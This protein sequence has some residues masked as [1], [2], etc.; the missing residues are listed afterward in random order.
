MLWISKV[1]M[2]AGVVLAV[3][4]AG[5]GTGLAVRNSWAGAGQDARPE[6]R[7]QAAGLPGAPSQ[8]ER[9]AKGQGGK[10]LMGDPAQLSPGARLDLEVRKL[11]DQLAAALKE[12]EDL[13]ANKAFKEGAA[14][15]QVRIEVIPLKN[16]AAVQVARV[17]GDLFQGYGIT[18]AALPDNNS[19]LVR[20][21]AAE[22][23]R[24]RDL[25]VQSLDSRGDQDLDV[26]ISAYT[27]GPLKHARAADVA[28]VLRSVYGRSTAGAPLEGNVDARNPVKGGAF[29]VAVDERTNSLVLA[30]TVARYEEA[31]VLTQRLEEAAAHAPAAGARLIGLKNAAAVDVAKVLRDIYGTADKSTAFSA[32]PRSNRLVIRCPESLA[33]EIDILVCE[34]D[35]K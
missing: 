27:L 17:L 32:D 3:L 29:S 30:C 33:A 7:A 9:N 1:K 21:N 18:V 11:R 16:A 24:I 14:P 26:S 5:T 15:G 2:A 23:R 25:V 31:R 34:L 19:L 6:A 13:K 20:A 10:G 22:L 28:N 12:I 4:V 35:V 8:P